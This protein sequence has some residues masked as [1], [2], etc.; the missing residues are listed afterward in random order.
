M[1]LAWYGKHSACKHRGVVF[2]DDERVQLTLAE[3]CV[4]AEDRAHQDWMNEPKW[5]FRTVR[6]WRRFELAVIVVVIVLAAVV[7]S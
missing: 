5:I 7:I 6:I 1:K 4:V 2:V 3:A